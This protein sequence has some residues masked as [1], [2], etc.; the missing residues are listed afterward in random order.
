[1]VIHTL[2]GVK[3]LLSEAAL[4]ILPAQPSAA[5]CQLTPQSHSENKHQEVIVQDTAARNASCMG[6]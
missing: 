5:W 4:Q 3:L 1:M 6:V 2:P